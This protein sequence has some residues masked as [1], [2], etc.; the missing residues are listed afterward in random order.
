MARGRA[1]LESKESQPRHLP[2]FKRRPGGGA[3]DAADEEVEVVVED[4]VG[5]GAAAGAAEGA[6]GSPAAVVDTTL[7][8]PDIIADAA[9]AKDLVGGLVG[10]AKERKTV[11]QSPTGSYQR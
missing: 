7:P 4:L 3:G 8:F 10:E 1:A 11:S 2:P 5:T 9:T 6:D